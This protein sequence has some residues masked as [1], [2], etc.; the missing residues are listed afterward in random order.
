MECTLILKNLDFMDSCKLSGILTFFLI[1]LFLTPSIHCQTDFDVKKQRS[2]EAIKALKE[3]VLVVRL[4]SKRNK[5]KA[6]KE[7]L[8]DKTIDVSYKRRTKKLLDKTI[9]ERDTYGK[10]MI[11]AFEEYYNFSKYLFIYDTAANHLVKGDFENIFL[12]KD[13]QPLANTTLENE[14]YYVLRNGTTDPSNTA[15]VEALVVADADNVDLEK[16]F[17]YYVRRTDFATMLSRIFS[18]NK[19]MTVSVKKSVSKLNSNFIKFYERVT[20]VN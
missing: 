5:I 12:D 1:T 6:L 17:P 3:G 15:G 14:N 19:A 16:P 7:V 8:M 2:Q 13:L 4:P 9:E 18:P 10:E 20:Y 11:A